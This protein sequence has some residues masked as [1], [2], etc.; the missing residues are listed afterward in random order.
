MPCIWGLQAFSGMGFN[1][2]N[3]AQEPWEYFSGKAQVA[4]PSAGP[5][6]RPRECPVPATQA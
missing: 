3:N 6:A 2:K 5:L 4:Q 1:F